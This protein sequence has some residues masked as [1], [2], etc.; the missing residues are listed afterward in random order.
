MQIKRIGLTLA[1]MATA[2]LMTTAC[3]DELPTY[4]GDTMGAPSAPSLP[5]GGVV[6]IG[7]GDWQEAKAP[8]LGTCSTIA[9]P[10]GTTL[11]SRAY[12]KGYQV[13]RWDGA[14]WTFVAPDAELFADA[15]FHGKLGTHYAGP[16]WES[17]SGST[18]KAALVTPCPVGNGNIPWLLL[19]A[20]ANAGHG[21]YAN[22][23]H[24]QRVN[25]VGGIA[26]ALAGTA[27]GEVKKVPYTAIYY[28]Y[29][30]G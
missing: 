20:T 1:A 27:V 14:A 9:A 7:D 10:A 6:V 8:E 15:G 5:N 25:T 17:N 4:P 2:V 21:P 26:P 16:T 12:A 3:S 19:G 22:V 23:T 11:A 13:Y 30:A 29:R 18:V 24:I 28:F